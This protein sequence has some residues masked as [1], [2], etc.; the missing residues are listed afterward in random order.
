MAL[1][2]ADTAIIVEKN[3]INDADTGS[4]EVQVAILTQKITYL[5]EHLQTHHKDHATRRGLL[6]M[7]GRR[8]RLLKYISN[9]DSARYTAL[10]K[11]LG[12]RR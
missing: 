9:T 10:I 8:R 11:S 12:L 2:A 4:V 7:V 1:T 5:T 6:A 3:R